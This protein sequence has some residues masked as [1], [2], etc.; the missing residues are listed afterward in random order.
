MDVIHTIH[1]FLWH[2]NTPFTAQPG[3]LV[4]NWVRC[5]VGFTYVELNR[6]L[7]AVYITWNC[8][9]LHKFIVTTKYYKNI[10]KFPDFINP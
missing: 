5:W 6:H 9:C 10:T 8:Y 1:N 7:F 2:I 3:S 4:A